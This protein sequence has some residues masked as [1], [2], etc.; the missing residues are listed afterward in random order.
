LENFRSG[1]IK[2]REREEGKGGIGRKT[3]QKKKTKRK[4]SSGNRLAVRAGA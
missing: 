4:M 1:E 2:L 3:D